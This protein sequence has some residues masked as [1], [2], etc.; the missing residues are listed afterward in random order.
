MSATIVAGD[1]AW[2]KNAR[3]LVGLKEIVGSKHEPKVLEFFA[4]AGHP[5]IHNDETAWCAAF[6][7]AMLRRAG[8]AGTGSLA[9]RSFL[10]WGE[11]LKTPRPGCIAVFKRGNSTWEGHVAFFLRD[12][13]DSIE[14]LGGNQGNA[15]SVTRMPK[16]SLLGYRW[17]T[18]TA[19]PAAKPAAQPAAPAKPPVLSPG[20]KAAPAGATVAVGGAGAAASQAG[21]SAPEIL[22]IITCVSLAAG[23]AILIIYRITKGY[24]PWTGN[25]SQEPLLPLPQ[26]SEKSLELASAQLALSSADLLAKPSPLPSAPSQPRKRSAKPSP[27]TRTPRKSSSASKAKGAKKSS[28]KR[29]SKSKS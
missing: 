26:P 4:E 15:V 16:A 27:R 24:W 19:A 2:L 11:G 28:P 13:G 8:Y 10:T 23:G 5:E 17:P 21:L 25:Q 7:N 9:A 29:K 3:E 22:A 12:L 6:A 20:A 1:P 14:V 18:I